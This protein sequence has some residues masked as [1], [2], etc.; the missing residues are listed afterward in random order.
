MPPFLLK[1]HRLVLY[2]R[3]NGAGVLGTSSL[4]LVYHLHVRFHHQCPWSAQES[5]QLIVLMRDA[6]GN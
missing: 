1:D 4:D 2:G 6:S 5:R 3:F